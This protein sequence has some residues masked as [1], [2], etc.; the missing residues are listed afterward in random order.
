MKKTIQLSFL[1]LIIFGLNAC[2]TSSKVTYSWK[3]D[4]HQ[5]PEIIS[6]IFVAALV[7]NPH[8]REHLE[9]DM[10][11]ST[12]VQGYTAEKSINYFKPNLNQKNPPSVDSMIEK[13]RELQ[14]ELIFTV[15]LTEKTSETRYIQG[16]TFYG[17]FPGYGLHFRSFYSYWYPF[18]YD[19]GYYVTD[20]KYF[21]E[22]NL[23]DTKT[24]I[25]LWT[26]QTESL[27]PASVEKFSTELIDLM[28]KRALLDLGNVRR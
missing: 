28:L 6:K 19:A 25:L 13:I 10:A 1:S 23:F 9:E 14:C 5:K 3:N 15:N 20:R 26:I 18:Y 21:M 12:T 27:N 11:I 4:A 16:S 7:R 22:G 24:G 17:P 8:V 2:G